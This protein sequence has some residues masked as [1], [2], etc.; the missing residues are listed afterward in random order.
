MSFQDLRS[1]LIWQGIT[2]S[3][4]KNHDSVKLLEVAFD[5]D[6]IKNVNLHANENDLHLFSLKIPAYKNL[7]FV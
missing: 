4:S 1:F 7:A 6:L 5:V 2:I 3:N